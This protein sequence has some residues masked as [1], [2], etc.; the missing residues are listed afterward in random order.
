MKHEQNED[1]VSGKLI[2]EALKGFGSNLEW[3]LTTFQK[4]G[5]PE[6]NIHKD[7]SLS[8]C[9]QMLEILKNESGTN[10]LF[11]LGLETSKV[12]KI[13]PI[14]NQFKTPHEIFPFLDYAYKLN[15]KTYENNTYYYYEKWND[16]QAIL[17]ASTPFH[18]E[19]QKGFLTGLLH[20]HFNYNLSQIEILHYPELACRNFGNSYC[21]YLISW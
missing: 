12:Y 6:I 19:F 2:L 1:K 5:I 7:Y 18:C 16:Q 9:I 13:P 8:D 4:H 3:I 11:K 17:R 15:I 21:N 20:Y 10:T 14:Y